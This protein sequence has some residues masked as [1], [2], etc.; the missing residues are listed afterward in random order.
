M[1]TL[2]VNWWGCWS[3]TG[4]RGTAAV[5]TTRP[6]AQRTVAVRPWRITATT[7]IGHSASAPVH[8][9]RMCPAGADSQEFLVRR[10][11]L[12]VDQPRPGSGRCMSAGGA[13]RQ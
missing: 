4:R 11:T 9:S 6:G 5:P 13:C 12:V 7:A 8:E 2:G 10:G 3:T 1:S